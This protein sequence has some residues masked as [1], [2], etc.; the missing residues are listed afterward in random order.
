[1]HVQR[2]TVAHG[3]WQ[4]VMAP[5]SGDGVLLCSPGLERLRA[6][7]AEADASDSCR[8]LVIRGQ[9]GCFCLGMDLAALERAG[10]EAV[11]GARRYADVLV[12]L[13]EHSKLTLAA[14][15]GEVFGGGVG[16]VAAT[17]AV[18]A[19]AESAF[20]LPEVTLGL[21]PA[22]VL[23]L[24]LD[25]MPRQKARLMALGATSLDASSAHR[26]GLV[27]EIVE[28]AK[29]LDR[30]VRSFARNALRA[31]PAALAE[32]KRLTGALS[33]FGWRE[34]LV[35]GVERTGK[36]LS[37]PTSRQRLARMASGEVPPWRMRYRSTT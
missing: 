26:V 37:T 27:D 18:V 33:A 25:R 32:V 17:D 30:R 24:L 9:P 13:A 14:V 1:V 36:R 12:A 35:K 3:V 21:T 29:A 2:E 20:G 11:V 5:T 6:L 8:L 7:L 15:D 34:G 16:L 10:D 31:D 4:L 23:P 22:M 19:T 28:D